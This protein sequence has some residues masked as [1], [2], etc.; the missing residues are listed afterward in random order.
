[1]VPV[2]AAAVADLGVV[3]VRAAAVADL[4]VLIEAAELGLAD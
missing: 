2:R 4:G 1:V 3:P